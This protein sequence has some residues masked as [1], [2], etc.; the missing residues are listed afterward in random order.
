M[1]REASPVSVRSAP[2]RRPPRSAGPASPAGRLWPVLRRPEVLLPVTFL[3]AILVG[4][5]VLSLPVCSRDDVGPL[6]AFFTATSAVC[7]TGL[8]VVD[9]GTGFTPAGQGVI[10]ALIQL[11]GLGMMT[12]SVLAMV[13]AGRR[14][15]LEQAAAVRE[16]FTA[17]GHWRL[18]RLLAVILGVT[19]LFEGIGF[20]VLY[21]QLGDAWPALFHSVSAF[22]NAGFS[23]FPASLRDRSGGV[24]VAVTAL[25][26]AGGLGFTTIIELGRALW[27][28]GK[29]RRGFSLQTKVVL[30][31][32]L[33]LWGLGTLLLWI[34]EQGALRHAWFMAATTRT[35]G[36]D[37]VA[38]A[39]MSGL[40]LLLLILVG[41]SPGSTGGGIKTTTLALAVLVARATLR[42]E[43]RVVAYGREIPRDLARRMFAVIASALVVVFLTVFLLHLF[44]GA[45]RGMLLDHAFEAVSAF[46]T[47]GLS[48]GVTPDLTPASKVLLCFVMF[49]GRVGSLSLFVLL[50]RSHKPSRVRYP[51]ERLMVG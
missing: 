30:K 29:G 46:G 24:V 34:T 45:P 22:C 4:W 23:I 49:I 15:S 26:V 48:T 21:A 14:V 37:T 35:A 20:L 32:T 42:G 2:S 18:G 38:P 3:A 28:G 10:A 44:E 16:T 7:V 17:V 47:V 12:F 39:D 40:S 11:G 36:F 8:V 6:E 5:I 50:V 25:F 19:V 33:L 27:P 9:T 51:E 13:L 31:T 41:A 1:I 43:E